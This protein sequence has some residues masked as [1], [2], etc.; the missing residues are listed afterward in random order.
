MHG[1]RGEIIIFN[2]KEYTIIL[3]F[4]LE[5]FVDD[6]SVQPIKYILRF[7]R[8]NI[9]YISLFYVVAKVGNLYS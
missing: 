1:K 6:Q 8:I 2:V 7:S 4:L 3:I 9:R 5:Y